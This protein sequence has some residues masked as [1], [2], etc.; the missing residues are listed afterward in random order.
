MRSWAVLDLRYRRRAVSTGV[1]EVKFAEVL[2]ARLA[3][4]QWGEGEVDVL[5]IPPMAQNVEL[6]WYSPAPRAMLERFGSFARFTAFDKRGTGSSSRRSKAPGLDERVEDIRAV[7][8][9]A[10]LERAHFFVQSEGGPMAVMFA[11]TYP[12]R[13]ES[14]SFFGAYASNVPDLSDEEFAEVVERNVRLWGTAQSVVVDYFAPSLADDAEFRSWHQSYERAAA[15][16]ES[17]RELLYLSHEID[18]TEVLP[19]VDVPTLVQHRTG[20]RIV[21]VDLGRVLAD[22]IPGAQFIEYPGDDHFAYAGDLDPWL[23]DLEEFI[24]GSVRPRKALQPRPKVRINVLGRFSVEIDGVEVP[25]TEWGSRHARQLCKRLVIGRGWPVPREQLI[26]MLWPN[27][28]DMRKLSARLSVQLSAVRRVLRGGVIADRQSVRLN[29]DEVSTDL[30]QLYRTSS[31]DSLSVYEGELLPDD[32]YEDWAMQPR[33]EARN[34]FVTGARS[35]LERLESEG[36]AS[37]AAELASRL[38]AIDGLDLNAWEAWIRSTDRRGEPREAG[39][40]YES[41][42]RAASELGVESKPLETIRKDF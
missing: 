39:R 1:P 21:S 18:V 15:S 27:E 41:Y 9:A 37:V 13:V 14:L 6:A 4:Q 24:T 28:T 11:V 7:M 31:L 17:L 22:G 10:G 38:V 8:D 35:E 33:I 30:E 36:A 16:Q 40:L 19:S 5:A 26:D 32:Q 20:D 29:L 25:K 34:R 12:D 42:N 3:F 23:S 2:G